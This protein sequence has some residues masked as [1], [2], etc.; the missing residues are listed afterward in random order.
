MKPFFLLALSFFLFVS[1]DFASAETNNCCPGGTAAPKA[2]YQFNA[3]KDGTVYFKNGKHTKAKLN[4]NYLHG[5]IEFIN[6]T[7]D[8]LVMTNKGRIDYIAVEE[9]IFYMQEDHGDTELVASF[10][11]ILLTKKTHLVAK[12][13]KANASEQKYMANPEAGTPTSL[14]I[15]N[16]G[17]EFRW[18]N[19]TV[20]PDYKF[21]TEYYFID[22]NH[23]FH[24]AKRTNLLKVFDKNK[25]EL[26][27]YLKRNDINFN[28]EDHLKKVLQF[29]ST[30]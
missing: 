3:F 19:N 23:L 22:R 1:P 18:Q 27:D 24:V 9:N 30:F 17:G 5:A 14:L 7:K 10:G 21:K 8:T 4:Y 12:G 2:V 26:S 16:Q 15:S 6:A 28:D 13:N 29:C 25:S 11:N 20:N